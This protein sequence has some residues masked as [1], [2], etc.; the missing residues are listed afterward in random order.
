MKPKKLNFAEVKNT[1][2]R[3]EMKKIMAGSGGGSGCGT[4]IS[5]SNKKKGD[6]CGSNGT[7]VCDTTGSATDT[8]LYCQSQP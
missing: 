7:C 4:G 5:C 3:N 6:S 2:S 8:T 1:L